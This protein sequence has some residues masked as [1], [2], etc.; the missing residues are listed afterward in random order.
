MIPHV[1]IVTAPVWSKMKTKFRTGLLPVKVFILTTVPRAHKEFVSTQASKA[2]YGL[3]IVWSSKS[4]LL[5]YKFHPKWKPNWSNI[6]HWYSTR[7]KHHM[8][9]TAMQCVKWIGTAFFLWWSQRTSGKF[10]VPSNR[11]VCLLIILRPMPHS[12]ANLSRVL[13][14]PTA[15]VCSCCAGANHHLLKGPG[16]RTHLIGRGQNQ[17][18]QD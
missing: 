5:H 9:R 1:P 6:A 13:V 17:T 7:D 12:S 15:N 14:Q 10:F 11:T 3:A 18:H 4:L 2:N 8:S 16:P